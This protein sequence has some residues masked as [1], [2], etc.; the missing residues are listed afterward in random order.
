M[1]L[2]RANS[3]PK[4]TRRLFYNV[5]RQLSNQ[6]YLDDVSQFNFAPFNVTEIR[7][8]CNRPNATADYL[9]NLTCKRHIKIPQ[10]LRGMKSQLIASVDWFDPNSVRQNRVTSGSCQTSWSWDGLTKHNASADGSD[11]MA[12]YRTCS[13]DERTH[14]GVSVPNFWHPGN[15][16]LEL[17]HHYRDDE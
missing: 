10:A 4:H 9:C 2:S 11:P 3:L 13:S 8:L 6:T 16:S 14:F 7:I 17:A 15:F 5:G 1:S 12:A